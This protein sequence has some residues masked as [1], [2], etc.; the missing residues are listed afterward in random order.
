MESQDLLRFVVRPEQTVRDAML[1]INGNWRELALVAGD[2]M[3][4]QGVITDGDIR[5][6]LLDG[7]TMDSQAASLMTRE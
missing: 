4:V 7:L 2:D 5:R 6:G 1:V 3:Q